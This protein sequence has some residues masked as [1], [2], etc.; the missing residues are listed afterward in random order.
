MLTEIIMTIIA[1]SYTCSD[2]VM[3]TK[4]PAVIS[5]VE[6][7]VRYH[8]KLR[9]MAPTKKKSQVSIN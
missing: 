1:V 4:S 7:D 5:T 2:T 6:I 8:V 3:Y 9:M